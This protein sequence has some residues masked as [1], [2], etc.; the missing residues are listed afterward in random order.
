MNLVIRF[1]RRWPFVSLRRV[2]EF[3]YLSEV[4]DAAEA[5][6]ATDVLGRGKRGAL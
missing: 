5:T 6:Y 3:V 1:R 4:P 2:F